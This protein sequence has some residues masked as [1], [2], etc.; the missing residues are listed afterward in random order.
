ML[1][2]RLR[3][4]LDKLTLTVFKRHQR[5]MMLRY[6]VISKTLLKQYVSKYNTLFF[7]I[8]FQLWEC[9][10]KKLSCLRDS[11]PR[12]LLRRSR[13]FKV[14]NSGTNWKPICHLQW[15]ILSSYLVPFPSY[16]AILVRFSL[17]TS[18][19][20]PLFNALVVGNVYEYRHKSYTYRRLFELHFGPVANSI[21]LTLTGLTQLFLNR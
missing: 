15:I 18:G 12:R 5:T 17:S 21:G 3:I 7:P 6:N 8:N 11:V 1:I 10:S 19:S 2:K 20:L 13:L 4:N 16:C 9:K 14:T